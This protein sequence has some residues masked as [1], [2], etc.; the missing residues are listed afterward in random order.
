MGVELLR[1]TG[2]REG[3]DL[4]DLHPSRPVDTLPGVT[5]WEGS[6]CEQLV[7]VA[8]QGFG[9][10]I[11]FLRHVPAAAALADRTVLAIHDELLPAVRKAP[12]LAGVTVLAKSRARAAIWGPGTR[13]ERLMSLPARLPSLRPEPADAYLAAPAVARA[14]G[15]L[16]VG[17]AWRSTPRRGF[18]GRSFPAR[19]CRLLTRLPGADVVTIHRRRDIRALPPGVRDPGITDFTDTATV[20]AAC[21]VVVTADT[22]TAHLARALGVPTLIC[23]RHEPD[24]R[25]GTSHAPTD[26]YAAAHLLFQPEPDQWEPVLRAATERIA[27]GQLP[28][29]QVPPPEGATA[30]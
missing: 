24:W 14:P 13:W 23:L 30:S 5:R 2:C 17:V 3:W 15:R 7:L 28:T 10:A 20:I 6:R 12:P 8:E 18:P 27:T 19:A 16:T 4:Y 25:W 1:A 29:R 9:D 11:Q 26:W 22:V 21:D